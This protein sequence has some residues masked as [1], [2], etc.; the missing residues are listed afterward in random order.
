MPWREE[1]E[2]S[3]SQRKQQNRWRTRKRVQSAMGRSLNIDGQSMLNFCS[4]DYLAL[5]NHP[6]LKAASI[7]AIETYGTGSGA[8]HLVCGHQDLHHQ[9]ELDLAEMLGC[10]QAI[11]FSTGYMAN[12]AVPQTFLGR[13]DL[14]LEDKL[15]HASLLDAGSIRAVKM[16]RYPHLDVDAVEKLLTDSDANRKMVLTDGTFSMDGDVAPVK[17]LAQLCGDHN[18]MLV[19]DDAHGFGV[20]G[21]HGGGLLQAEGIS[22]GK[23]VLMVGTLGKSA[24]SFGAFIAGDS[25]YIQSLVQFARTYIYTTSLPPAVAAA[26]IAAI[27]ITQSEPSRRE[28]L[29]SS[30]ERFRKEATEAGLPLMPSHTAI[31]PIVLGSEEKALAADA[32]LRENGI[33]AIAIRP[34]TVPAGSARIRLTFRA[35]HTDDD[36]DR[37]LAVLKSEPFL[38]LVAAEDAP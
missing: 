11:V 10:E 27:K 24:G 34:P 35:D 32:L 1:I 12:L 33:L 4:N 6:T 17:Q 36:M 26:S 8:S 30:I 13:N 20:L 9:L 28:R 21:E 22:V 15:N 23:N 19:V 2:N 5:A 7:E 25:P 16:K 31:Q 18:A 38:R 37:L 14:L 29:K 3:F